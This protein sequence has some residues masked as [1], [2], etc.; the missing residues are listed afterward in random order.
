MD[1][2]TL[3]RLIGTF[4]RDGGKTVAAMHGEPARKLL[5]EVVEEIERI[6]EQEEPL[7]ELWFDFKLS[8]DDYQ[9]ELSELLDSLGDRHPGFQEKLDDFFA[10]YDYGKANEIPVVRTDMVDEADSDLYVRDLDTGLYTGSEI[11]DTGEEPGQ[12]AESERPDDE[13]P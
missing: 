4:F 9:F 8:P 1:V 2:Y 13:Q 12:P 6:M 10:A 3:V 11:P 5:V 7:Q